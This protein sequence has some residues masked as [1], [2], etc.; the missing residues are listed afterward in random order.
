MHP[1]ALLLTMLCTHAGA[2]APADEVTVDQCRSAFV[3]SVYDPLY[4]RP[5]PVVPVGTNAAGGPLVV[6]GTKYGQGFGCRLFSI[7]EL[8]APAGAEAIAAVAG[9]DD[10]PSQASGDTYFSLWAGGR[11]LWRS[12]A[13][14]QADAAIAVSV[15]LGGVREV[16]LITDSQG[17]GNTDLAD[18]C[19]VRWTAEAPTELRWKWLPAAGNLLVRPELHP[20]HLLY[21]DEDLPV[22]VVGPRPGPVAITITLTDETGQAVLQSD[23]QAEMADTGQGAYVATAFLPTRDLPNGLYEGTLAASATGLTPASRHLRFGII[24]SQIGSPAPGALYGVNHHE[25]CA[26]YEALAAAGA[27]YSRQWFCWDWIEH[28]IDQWSFNWH[29]ERMACAREAG[30]ETIGVLGGIGCPAWSSPDHVQA[31]QST[32]HGCPADLRDWEQYVRAVATRYKGQ[33]KVWESWNE[34]AGPA[35]NGRQGWSVEGYVKLHRLT[36]EVLKQVDPEN[37]VLLCADTLAFVGKCLQAG[38]GDAFDGIVIHPYRPGATPERGIGNA[39]VGN[40]GDVSSVFD[41]S[42][43]WLADHG[44]PDAEVWATEIGWALTGR[45]WPVI[46][47]ETHA[48]YVPRTYLLAQSSGTAANACWHDF[49]L[50]MFGI[51]NGQGYPRNAIL[52]YAGMVGR[53]GGAEVTSRGEPGSGLQTALLTRYHRPVLA[54]WC[55]EDTAFAR[56]VP[57]SETTVERYDWL[58]NRSDLV[59]PRA[60]RVLTVGGRITYLEGDGVDRVRV[61]PELPLSLTVGEVEVRA[62]HETALSLRIANV[63]GQAQAFSVSVSGAEGLQPGAVPDVHLADGERRD[64]PL[65]LAAGR[66]AQPGVR[67]VSVSVTDQDGLGVTLQG[68]IRIAP[69]LAVAVEPFDTA[70]LGVG[71]VRLRVGVRNDDD[72]PLQGSVEFRA[73]E[74]LAVT[75]A[76]L[77][78][79]TLA[80]G[81]TAPLSTELAAARAIRSEDS[82]QVVV[83]CE[84]GARAEVIRSLAPT[85][86]DADGNGLADGWRINPETTSEDTPGNIA[87]VSIEPGGS[88]FNCQRIDCPRFRSGWIIL[89]RDGADEVIRDAGYRITFRARQRGLKGT[90]GVA[91]YN[92]RPWEC[93]GIEKQLR[94]GPD[95]QTYTA[96]FRATRDSGLA[97]FEFFFTETGTLWL[98]GIRLEPLMR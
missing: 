94:I 63:F 20:C 25:F 42:A 33:V 53:L 41:A 38:L 50:G 51:C 61:I 30:I 65:R 28:E 40:V 67:E 45:D 26:S 77:P 8:Q 70:A 43:R 92:I 36:Y 57:P 5:R 15:P 86:L 96:E 52:A 72:R 90:V 6:D 4:G 82:L 2:Q 16:K 60:G 18:W 10:H 35:Q 66:D 44:R 49:G 11:C 47:E 83:A 55:E 56:V 34:I 22:T 37:R 27:R 73:P 62:G 81:A 74:G 64:I 46:S 59:L 68:T 54:L 87:R 89:H 84:D 9:I 58:G 17:Y 12:P 95:W 88:E 97:R 13:V 98:E 29:D 23:L 48:C 71:P 19:N 78:L 76:R 93:C 69:P 7:V 91:V 24:A 32:T 85:I 39:Q 80:P 3:Y 79:P 1:L 75:P 14:S 31:G 21:D